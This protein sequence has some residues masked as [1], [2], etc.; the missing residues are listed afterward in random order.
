MEDGRGKDQSWQFAKWIFKVLY[1]PMKAF[2]E[3]MEKPSVKGPILILL[4]TLPIALSGQ[5]VSGTKFF[6]ESPTPENDLWTEAPSNSLSFSWS[7]NANVAFD[8]DDYVSGEYSVSI[9]LTDTLLVWARLTDVGSFNCSEE[10]YS[11]FSFSVKW[12]SEEN[13]TPAALLQLFSLNNEST[14]FERDITN[15]IANKTGRWG[16]ITV[17]LATDDWVEIPEGL[18][19]WEN[20][21]GI[22]FQVTW[23]NLANVT[24]KIDDMF[25][26]K[27]TSVASSNTFDQQLVYSLTRS[28]ISFLLEWLILSGIAFLTLKSFFNWTGL[29]KNLLATV[30]YVYSASIIQLVALTLLFLL[31]PPI[32]LPYNITYVEYLD[33]YQRSWGIPISVLSLLS[34]VWTTILCAVALKS[35]QSLSWMQAFLTGFGAV[36]ISLL[37][38]SFL[39]SA[40]L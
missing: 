26:G 39:L 6:L 30:G 23:P 1:S 2:R 3:I 35:L 19:S 12:V 17:N 34:Y 5:Y 20:V 8:G 24:L 28:S 31:L 38:S 9:S 27:Y 33:I 16:N 25:F 10:E 14:R 32:F 4:I 22:G 13:A 37:L 11:R 21:T 29:W 36:V 15:S 40:F 18:P 7:S